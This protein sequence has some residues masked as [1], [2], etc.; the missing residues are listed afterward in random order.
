MRVIISAATADQTYFRK[1]MDNA[2]SYM[3]TNKIP[4]LVQDRVRTWYMHTW[5]S[6]GMLGKVFLT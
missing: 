2:V 6:Q 4:K 3:N 1:S 5:E